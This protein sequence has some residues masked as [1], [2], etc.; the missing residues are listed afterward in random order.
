MR[1]RQKML[2]WWHE[3]D[4]NKSENFPVQKGQLWNFP[5]QV[6]EDIQ[7]SKQ[8]N[9]KLGRSTKGR[10]KEQAKAFK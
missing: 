6:D 10:K 4:A 8:G 2:A 1:C 7:R 9:E 3:E 5:E